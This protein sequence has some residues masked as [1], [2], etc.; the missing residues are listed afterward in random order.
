MPELEIRGGHLCERHG[1]VNWRH[2]DVSTIDD[3]CP[4]GVGVQGSARIEATEGGLAS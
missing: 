4:G 3:A 2:G 1:I